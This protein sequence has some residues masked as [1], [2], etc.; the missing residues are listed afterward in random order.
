MNHGDHSGHQGHSMPGMEEGIQT[1]S[2]NMLWN[3][4]IKNTCV[5][6]K[7]WHINGSTSMFISC[8]LIIGISFFYSF[9]LN[10]IKTFDRKIALSIYNQNSISSS[11][12]SSSNS[13]NNRREN[14]LNY[15]SIEIGSLSKIG[16][17]KL[18]LST[19]IIRAILYSISIALSFWLMLVAM[20]YNTY[21]FSSIIIGAFLG[22]ITYEEEMDVGS[23]LAGGN[24]KGLACH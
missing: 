5:V 1:C 24:S 16:M 11:S 9:L 7:S 14:G 21:L 19:R 22:H 4:Q 20:T 12:I 2:M 13:N 6:F 8:I 15:N 18:S 17:I 23:V 10:Y 3:N